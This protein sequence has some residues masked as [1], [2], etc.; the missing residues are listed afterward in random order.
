MAINNSK[1]G[2]KGW[3]CTCQSHWGSKKK[4]YHHTTYHETEVEG[5]GV[6]VHCGHYAV[7]NPVMNSQVERRWTKEME[8]D[9]KYIAARAREMGAIFASQGMLVEEICNG[10]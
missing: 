1:F 9:A 3:V 7:L 8:T 10:Q 2:L 6:C 4:L 5:D